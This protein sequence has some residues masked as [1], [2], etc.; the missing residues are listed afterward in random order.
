M[1]RFIIVCLMAFLVCSCYTTKTYTSTCYGTVTAYTPQGEILKQWDNATIEEKSTV[2]YN[3][4]STTIVQGS[5]PFKSY[6]LNFIDNSTGKGVI[7]H[8]DIPYII[9]YSTDVEVLNMKEA[10]QKVCDELLVQYRKYSMQVNSNKKEMKDLDKK[11]P[12]YKIKKEQNEK[13]SATM[14]EIRQQYWDL[15]G[16][17]IYT[18]L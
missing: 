13:L 4:T 5:T 10:N 16:E 7:I 6:G 9:E 14:E 18:K 15:S 17:D 3:G 12:E 8:S 2:V 1:K 11:S